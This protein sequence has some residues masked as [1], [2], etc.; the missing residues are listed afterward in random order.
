LEALGTGWGGDWEDW[1]DQTLN[2]YQ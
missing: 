2:Y 1:E